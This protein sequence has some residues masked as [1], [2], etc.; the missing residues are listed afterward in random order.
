M[1]TFAK[2]IALGSKESGFI[3]SV[4]VVTLSALA[5]FDRQMNTLLCKPIV[6]FVMAVVTK[7]C[8]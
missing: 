8:G 7:V 5:E 1:A 2:T 4:W 3:R 6:A